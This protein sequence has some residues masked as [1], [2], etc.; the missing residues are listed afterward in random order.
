MGRLNHDQESRGILV[1]PMAR[2]PIIASLPASELAGYRW[3]LRDRACYASIRA[4][5]GTKST[6][7]EI[8]DSLVQKPDSA[9]PLNSNYQQPYPASLR[10]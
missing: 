6:N 5:E 8:E 7:H 3:S 1:V 9:E 10:G 2:D 4:N